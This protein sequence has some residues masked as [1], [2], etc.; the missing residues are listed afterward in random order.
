MRH[1]GCGESPRHRSHARGRAS[2][3]G[4]PRLRLLRRGRSPR[5]RS[6][7][8]PQRG[9]REGTQRTDPQ[10]SAHGHHGDRA[11]A[12]GD[13]RRAR[14]LQRASAFFRKPHRARSQ[15]HHRELRRTARGTPRKGLRISESDRYRGPDALHSREG[16]VGFLASRRRDGRPAAAARQLRHRR[17]R[18]Q[19]TRSR[20]R[21]PSGFAP[22]ARARRRGKLRRLGRHGRRRHHGP[23]RLPRGGRRG[24]NHDRRLEGLPPYGRGRLRAR[25]PSGQGRARLFRRRGARAL[26]S[27]HAEGNL[28]AAARHRRHARRR[29]GRD[30]ASFRRKGRGDLPRSPPTP[31]SCLRHVLLCGAHGQVL[32]RRARAASLRRRNRERIPLSCLGARSR[33]ARR[34][35]FAVGR[36]C[37]H[38]R[39]PAARP[40]RTRHEEDPHHLQRGHLH[41]GHRVRTRLRDARGRG[42]GRRLDQ[43]LHDAVDGALSAR[44]YARQGERSPRRQDGG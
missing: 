38:A 44:P 18:R 27:L 34:H 40:R 29:D 28:R 43:G 22:G 13:A 21:G 41:D 32:D 6:A 8:R 15:R 7:A 39:R 30:A 20:R 35:D 2:P 26:S 3:F 17:D 11:H 37:G 16:E 31:V 33:H 4:I 5:R 10:G 12:L 14:R 1:C 42:S 25:R 19:G 36:D 9:P 24:R 23:L